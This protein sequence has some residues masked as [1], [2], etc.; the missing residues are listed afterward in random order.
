M[1]DPFKI[2][3]DYMTV[4]PQGYIYIHISLALAKP[5]KTQAPVAAKP[6]SLFCSALLTAVFRG[7]RSLPSLPAPEELEQPIDVPATFA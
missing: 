2:I 1:S 6:M 5:D 3:S 4:K 7:G